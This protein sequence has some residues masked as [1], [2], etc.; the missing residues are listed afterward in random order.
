MV[1]Q[2]TMQ[3]LPA[4]H[5]EWNWVVT[6]LL[7]P[8]VMTNI[9]Q[10]NYGNSTIEIVI[11]LINSMVIFHSYLSLQEGTWQHPNNP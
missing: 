3:C 9:T 8:L 5:L 11:C 1:N 7:Y 6:Q 10:H 4:I 2:Q